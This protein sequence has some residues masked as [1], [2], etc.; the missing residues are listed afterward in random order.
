VKPTNPKISNDKSVKSVTVLITTYK[1]AHLLPHV[2]Q[3]LEKQT[4]QNF[5]ILV[6]VKL[7]GDGTETVV[8]KWAK[9]LRINMVTQTNN[10]VVNAISLGLKYATGDII[11]FLDDDAIPFADWIQNQLENYAKPDIGGVAGEV[12]PCFLEDGKVV[13][14]NGN[15]SE[16]ISNVKPFNDRV[17]RKLWF[18][19]L[20][21]LEDYLVYVSKAG[22]VNYNFDVAAQA[23]NHKTK[24]LLGMGANMSVLAKSLEGFNFSDSWVLGLSYEQFLGW[25]IWK[26]GY[27][28]VFN[29]N[30]KVYHIAHGETLSRNVTNKKSDNLRQVESRLLFYRLYGFEPGLS[31]MHRLTWLIFDTVT[32]LKKICTN[33]EVFRIRSLKSK[34][35]SEIIGAKWLLSKRYGGTYRPLHDLESIL[36]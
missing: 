29:P 4:N 34:F 12:I 31:K 2:F 11:A 16:I 23:Y 13:Q 7:S 32:D 24:S 33:K 27:D 14:L 30:A 6:V 18:C 8:E 28:I 17:A 9:R 3:A 5:D 26:K 25:H 22:M 21:G 15:S 1:R 10:H 35:R 19:P 20:N 36:S